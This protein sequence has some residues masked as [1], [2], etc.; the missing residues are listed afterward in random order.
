MWL[1]TRIKT[2]IVS[3]VPWFSPPIVTISNSTLQAFLAI[4]VR[5]T[6][7]LIYSAFIVWWAAIGF[8]ST[9]PFKYRTIIKIQTF[10]KNKMKFYFCIL[11][12]WR[13]YVNSYRHHIHNELLKNLLDIHNWN[14]SECHLPW[15]TCS[16]R[17]LESYLHYYTSSLNIFLHFYMDLAH[18]L[19]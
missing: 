10:D 11:L 3:H 15:H 1:F 18:I 12:E 7:T 16:S 13:K 9:L 8:T 6:I 14:F 5:F 19:L 2:A 4:H 17:S